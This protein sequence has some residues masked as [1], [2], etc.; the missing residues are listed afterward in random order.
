MVVLFSFFV[1]KTKKERKRELSFTIVRAFLKFRIT[2][3]LIEHAAQGWQ[4]KT[5]APSLSDIES[6]LAFVTGLSYPIRATG[7][8]GWTREPHVA[9]FYIPNCFRWSSR[10]ATVSD[11]LSNTW[12]S[13]LLTPAWTWLGLSPPRVVNVR[14]QAKDILQSRSTPQHKESFKDLYCRF[15][16]CTGVTQGTDNT[17]KIKLRNK[18]AELLQVRW[19]GTERK[20]EGGLNTA[21]RGQGRLLHTT[22][23]KGGSTEGEKNPPT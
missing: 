1:C 21:G 22:E 7:S 3:F 23:T 2:W 16:R 18:N 15:S 4:H 13:G 11:S 20:E 17:I 12:L 19:S 8:L 14:N 9:L 5:S 6:C 10:T